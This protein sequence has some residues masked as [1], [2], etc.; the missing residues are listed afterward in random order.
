MRQ[1]AVKNLETIVEEC[2]AYR[3]QNPEEVKGHWA[4]FFGNDHPLYVEIGSGK[5]K[6]IVEHAELHP[7]INYLAVEAVGNVYVRILQKLKEKDLPN[8]KAICQRMLQ[9]SDFFGDEELDK[10]YL[11]F[12]DPWPKAWQAKRRLTCSRLLEQYYGILKDGG[13][14]EFKTDNDELFD[15]SLEE[16]EASKF[17]IEYVT[18]DLHNSEFAEGN[19]MTEYEEKFSSR[20]KNINFVIVRKKAQK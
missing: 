8:I 14:I 1:R 13:T 18:R 12:S 20:G 9:A 17:D 15:Y 5:G 4:E 6:F 3:V 16:F 2:A 19:I 7:E 11:N 10:I